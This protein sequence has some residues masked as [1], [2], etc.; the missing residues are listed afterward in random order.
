MGV[1]GTVVE[2]ELLRMSGTYF[3]RSFALGKATI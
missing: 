3:T 2:D 1:D